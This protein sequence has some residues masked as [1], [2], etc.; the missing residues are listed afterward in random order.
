M[1]TSYY[2]HLSHTLYSNLCWSNEEQSETL[3]LHYPSISIHAISRDTSSFPHHCVYLMYC[4]PEEE[5]M[6]VGEEGKEM[7]EEEEVEGSQLTEIRL[8]PPEPDQRE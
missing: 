5:E 8:V 6:E 1:L 4:P 2:L 7:E 3:C